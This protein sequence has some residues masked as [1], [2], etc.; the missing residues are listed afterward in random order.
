MYKYFP[1]SII[2]IFSIT[3]CFSECKIESI[4][5]PWYTFHENGSWIDSGNSE[6]SLHRAKVSAYFK[7]KFLPKLKLSSKITVDFSEKRFENILENAY[8]SLKIIPQI[9][10]KAGKFKVP[11][12]AN[13]LM[14]SLK[15]PTIYRSFTTDHMKKDLKIAGFQKGGIIY[16][17]L[18]DL[19]TYIAGIFHYEENYIEGFQIKDIL[20]FPVFSLTIEPKKYLLF[21][22]I[23]I[24]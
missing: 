2:I 21:K 16:G 24:R 15:L 11:I 14:S 13:N 7:K 19:V 20:D 23:R 1:K 17:T 5:Q 3:L 8:I 4:I 10:L 9:N 22:Y 12:G 6:I 18:F